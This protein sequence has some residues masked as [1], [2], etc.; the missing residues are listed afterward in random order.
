MLR[1]KMLEDLKPANRSGLLITSEAELRRHERIGDDCYCD[2]RYRDLLG[3]WGIYYVPEGG[4]TGVT[5]AELAELIRILKA[6]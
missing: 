2:D 3:A 6:L 1:Y 5:T 4:K